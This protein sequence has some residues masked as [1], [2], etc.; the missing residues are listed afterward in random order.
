MKHSHII[1]KINKVML[2]AIKFNMTSVFHNSTEN[3]F[4]EILSTLARYSASR[5]HHYIKTGLYHSLS[6]YLLDFFFKISHFCDDV[7]M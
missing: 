1:S 7:A 2:N 3:L 6:Y 5:F 4:F